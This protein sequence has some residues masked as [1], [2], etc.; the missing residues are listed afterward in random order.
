VPGDDIDGLAV[1]YV[2]GAALPAGWAGPPDSILLSLAPGSPS[3]AGMASACFGP[4]TG[5]GGDVFSKLIPGPGVPV[6]AVDAEMLGLNT[7]RS[8][9]LANDNIED[10]DFLVPA[11][12]DGDGDLIDDAVDMDDDNE[13]LGDL[14]DVASGC[15]PVSADS[16]GDS[17][18][19]F[20]EVLVLGTSCAVADTDGDGCT[21]D[22]EILVGLGDE[23]LGGWRDPLNPND[24]FN[25]TG[26]LLN[27][28]D[29]VLAVVNQ[30]FVDDADG[31]P[32]LPPYVPGY[33][34]VTDRTLLGPDPWD[35][36]PPNGL[37][38]VDDILYQLNQYFHDCV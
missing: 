10:F 13:G 21:D 36:G 20:T 33:T 31:T 4:A 3:L 35:T 23:L 29:D 38:R 7:I 14:F 11:G 27:R 26:D 25:P 19:D 24:Y 30:Y 16:D 12:I 15:S 28:V 17:I 9:G 5:T 37:Q 8:G 32:G 1:G 22:R 2:S 18:D 6:P 34:P